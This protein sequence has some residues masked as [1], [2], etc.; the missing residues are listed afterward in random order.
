MNYLC[1][2]YVECN[3]C[4]YLYCTCIASMRGLF[5]SVI[6]NINSK[7]RLGR[8]LT[9]FGNTTLFQFMGKLIY[10]WISYI[11]CTRG[12]LDKYNIR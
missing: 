2:A 4:I 7:Q 1:V 5:C 11:Y 9:L 12:I 10:K 6:N 8:G 3:P